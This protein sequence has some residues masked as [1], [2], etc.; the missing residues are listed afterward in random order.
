MTR[1]TYTLP[2]N[3]DFEDYSDFARGY[4]AARN[5]LVENAHGRWWI[6]TLNCKE[7]ARPEVVDGI[8]AYYRD[9]D[10]R[11]EADTLATLRQF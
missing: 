2:E 6:V 9:A 8:E 10:A 3:E 4:R 7:L 5:G 11:D 1:K